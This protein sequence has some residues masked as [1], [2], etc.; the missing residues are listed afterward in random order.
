MIHIH[1]KTLQDLE[2]STV[3]QQVSD[4]CVTVLGHEKAL[5]IAPFSTKELLLKNLNLTNEYLST[6][7]NDNSIPNHGFDAINKEIKLLRIE[8][9]YLEVHGLKKIVSISLTTN[10][11][12]TFLKKF[13]AYYPNLN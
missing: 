13:E 4:H 5:Q 11:I 7:Y 2:F 10:E 12:V 8:N 6:F 3:L 9:T 1:E